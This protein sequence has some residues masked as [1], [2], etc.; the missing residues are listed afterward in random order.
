MMAKR[1][2]AEVRKPKI[3]ESFYRTILEEGFEGA[4][5]AKVA[6]RLDIHPSLILHYFGNK[7]NMT[8]ACVDFVIFEYATLFR[9]LQSGNMAPEERLA[10]LVK[11]LWSK[12]YYEKIHIA[13]SLS[14]ITVSFR[15][16]R[17]RKKI[18][19]LYRLFKEYLIKELKDLKEKGV[20]HAQD[21]E[22]VADVLVTMV[23]GSRHFCH[24]FI[25]A[26][27]LKQY[28]QD[29]GMAALGMLTNASWQEK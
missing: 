25:K 28:N 3:I 19:G 6:K 1:Q 21:I 5:I 26:K 22:R 7:E 11:T 23:E 2:C 15:N 8:L 18:K 12:A 24:F 29:M 10:K 17:V 27:D 9:K 14:V 13:A 16:P 4:S 20:I